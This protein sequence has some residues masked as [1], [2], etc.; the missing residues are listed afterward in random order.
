MAD[1]TRLRWRLAGATMW[2]AFVL[3]TLAATALLHLLPFTGDEG[4]AWIPSL[5]LAGFANLAVVAAAAPIAGWLL[6]RR[7]RGLPQVVAADRAGTALLLV[8]LG[9][10]LAGGIAHRSTVQR[11][12]AAFAHQAAAAERAIRAQAPPAFRDGVLSTTKQGPGLYRTCAAGP[13]AGEAFCVIVTTDQS[14][15]GVTIDPDR[16]PNEVV[17]GPRNPGRRGR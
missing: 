15:P 4:L 14:P 7:V 10:L 12:R 17:S 13:D 1:L 3:T 6:R 8:L 2:P 5:L 9:A 11:E 16:R